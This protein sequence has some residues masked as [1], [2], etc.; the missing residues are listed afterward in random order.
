MPLPELA[1]L[2]HRLVDLEIRLTHQ[3]ATLEALNEVVIRQQ[4]QIDTL[5]DELG[6]ARQ[7]LSE[8]DASPGSAGRHE[9][10]PHY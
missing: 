4:Q 7:R 3:D 10:P 1:E 9:P 6:K 2:S 8:L 5:S